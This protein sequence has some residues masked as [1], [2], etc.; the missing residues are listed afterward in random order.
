MTENSKKTKPDATDICAS[1][2]EKLK[3]KGIDLQD[4][5][6]DA[7]EGS[8]VKV[9]CIS[10]DMGD[11]VEEMGLTTRGETVMVR[12]DEETKET[13][14]AW[15]ETGYFKS[16]SEAAALFIREGLKIR[17]SELGSLKDALQKLKNAK[18]NLHK[19]ASRIFGKDVKNDK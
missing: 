17:A 5:V 12:I 10:S 4:L 6:P 1:V 15:V 14:D 19:K 9:I 11:S 8:K 18:D 3:K 13:L 2:F 7:K 16:R